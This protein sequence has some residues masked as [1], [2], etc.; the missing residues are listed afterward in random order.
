M[1]VVIGLIF[2]A[3]L[4]GIAVQRLRMPYT[5]GLVIIGLGL[6]LVVQQNAELLGIINLNEFLIP[7]V[8]LTILVPPL[9][10][11]AAFHIKFEDLR[12][13]LREILTFA[14]PGVL[15]TMLLVGYFI[16]LGTSLPLEVA[17]IFGALIAATDPVAVVALFRTLGVPKQLLILL[18]GESLFN[19]GT[20]IVI[21][22]LMIAIAL[23]V[24]EFQL[25]EFGA[26]FI[27]TAGGG[28][29]AGLLVGWVISF[30]IRVVN[31]H[32]IEVTLTTVAAYGSYI[33]AEEFHVSGVLAV[34]AAGLVIGNIGERGMSPTTRLSLFNFWEF[35]AYLTNSF[36]F[37]LIG[38][39]INVTAL[40]SRWQAILVAIAAVLVARAIV[41]YLFSYRF[42]TITSKM[43]HVIYWGGLRGAI[44]LALALSIPETLGTENQ[45]LLQDMTFG[46]VL[47]TL[48][49]QGTTMPSIIKRLG[50]GARSKSQELFERHQ[51]RAIAAQRSYDHLNQMHNEGLISDHA[52][53]L[54]EPSIQR[55]IELRKE[56]VHEIMHA[57]PSVEGTELEQ[58]FQEALRTQ[59][60]TYN[61][62]LSQ[63]TIDEETFAVLINEV[64]AALVNQ[65]ISYGDLLIRRTT[66][67][68]PIN[69]LI[70]ASISEPDVYEA[71]HMLG[72]LGI[73]AIRLSSM[74]GP[75]GLVSMTLL[76]GV[77][78]DLVDEVIDAI[79]RSS[80]V[81]AS[82]DGSLFGLLRAGSTSPE[83][84]DHAHI[85]IFDVLHYE[86]I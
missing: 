73:P 48:L 42:R 3:S 80:T 72:I 45:T 26:D 16:S 75:S 15:V 65:D 61:S 67:L 63:G 12:R 28:L 33:V 40:I 36:A 8:I 50:F 86:E 44:S 53:N 54:M 52:W 46:V 9:I 35:G 64:D 66:D 56:V 22:N 18:E 70:V 17:L 83:K 38:L 20:A 11:E 69:K 37:L 60:S 58:A 59:R 79:E 5:V 1:Q 78:E 24:T 14:I 82:T 84:P 10:F 13:N 47:F 23:G 29:I 2:I 25:T 41:I 30:I 21:Y 62:L 6:A 7:E 19:D 81:S 4:V 43:R 55:Q 51:A 49:V 68:P 77:E 34:V 57:D 27:L 31:N 39:V 76:I 85:F 74:L 71:L 32:L